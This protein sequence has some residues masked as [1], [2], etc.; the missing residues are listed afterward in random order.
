M[1]NQ[2]RKF[3]P[4]LAKLTQP[5]LELLSSKS[6]WEWS[7]SQEK[8]FQDVLAE[9]TKP[10]VL[11]LYDPSADTKISAD[12]S[13]YGIGAVL[14]QKHQSSWKPTAFASHSLSKTEHRYAQIEK[15]VLAVTWACDTFSDY[16]LGKQIT[17]ETDHKPLVPLLGSEH[18]DH[19][20]PRIL[21]F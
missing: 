11:A 14:L 3:T 20:P 10:T 4:K 16:I 8:A 6:V 21:R 19:V 13:S 12:A 17:L 1:A 5:L 15:E 18:L 9:L 7:P 2:L